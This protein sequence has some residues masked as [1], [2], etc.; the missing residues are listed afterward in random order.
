MSPRLVRKAILQC[1]RLSV[2]GC[3]HTTVVVVVVAVVFN[4]AHWAKGFS[5]FAI[6]IRRLSHTAQQLLSPQLVLD[7]RSY[8]NRISH[9]PLAISTIATDAV[10]VCHLFDR[11]RN[12]FIVSAVV[13]ATATDFGSST[14]VSISITCV[15]H[16]IELNDPSTDYAQKSSLV[17]LFS[18]HLTRETD[19]KT[20]MGRAKSV[21]SGQGCNFVFPLALLFR[22]TTT[23]T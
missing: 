9:L 12:P 13:A 19:N 21:Y 15:L 23:R 17:Y 4:A 8:K 7:I 20:R 5:V 18:T 14:S 22:P 11:Q 2:Y 10:A 16:I 3:V 6:T 1:T